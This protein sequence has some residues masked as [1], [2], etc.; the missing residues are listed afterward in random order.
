[1]NVDQQFP[2]I[3]DEEKFQVFLFVCPGNMPFN[4]ALHPWFVINTQGSFSRYEV[5]FRRGESATSFGHVHKNFYPP[6]QGIEIISCVP[7]FFWK[8]RLLTSLEGEAARRVADFIERSPTIYPY[9]DRY[10]LGG[11]DS[12][13]YAQWVLNQFPEWKV[14][15]PWNCFGKNF[16]TY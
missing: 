13:T 15:L 14:R 3:V 1:M 11:P 12:D 16:R 6:F 9:R 10:F 8:P 5:L 4:F 2:E 7:R